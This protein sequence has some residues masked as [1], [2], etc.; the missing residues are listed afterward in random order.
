MY[1]KFFSKWIS[2]D[3]RNELKSLNYPGIYIV[4]HSKRKLTGAK[5][6]W[7]KEIIYIGMTNAVGGLKGR[8]YQF[9]QAIGGKRLTHGGA[10]RVRFKHQKY[11]PFVSHAYVAV[12][13]FKCD[14]S[15]LKPSD[16]KEMGEVAKFEYLCFS[17]HATKYKCLPEFNRKISPKYSKKI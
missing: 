13:S 11:K 15:S 7:V 10:D 6:S 5:F 14:V 8:L 16:L 4:A 17:E 2:W 9:D 1:E 3:R 12:A